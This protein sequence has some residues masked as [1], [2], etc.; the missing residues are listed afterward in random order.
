MTRRNLAG[1]HSQTRA[2]RGQRV[3]VCRWL[4]PHTKPEVS[5]AA[6]LTSPWAF[7]ANPVGL[8]RAMRSLPSLPGAGC[9]SCFFVKA[10]LACFSRLACT[11]EKQARRAAWVGYCSP[12][13]LASWLPPAPHRPASPGPLLL[14]RDPVLPVLPGCAPRCSWVEQGCLSLRLCML[15]CEQARELANTSADSYLNIEIKIRNHVRER[16]RLHGPGENGHRRRRH[17]VEGPPS[18]GPLRDPGYYSCCCYYYYCYYYYYYSTYFLQVLLSLF[19]RE[20]KSGEMQNMPQVAGNM[21]AK[22]SK[23]RVGGCARKL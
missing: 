11:R 10:S 6:R 5:L 7:S 16:P 21:L 1:S 23:C 9:S 17:H 12:S 14:V 15:R 13:S 4:G 8:L 2:A 22:C 19:R 18:R 20:G 3:K